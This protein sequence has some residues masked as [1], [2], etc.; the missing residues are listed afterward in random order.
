MKVLSIAGLWLLAGGAANAQGYFDFDSVPGLG[1]QPAVQIDLNPQML[2]FVV[3]MTRESDPEA[4]NLLSSIEGVR[5]RVYNRLDD[6]DAVLEFID[7]TSGI[8]ERDGWQRAVYVQEDSERVRLYIK[9]EGERMAGM[10]VMVA[11]SSSDEA[12]F[13]NVVGQLDP[14][15]LGRLARSAGFGGHVDGLLGGAAGGAGTNG[16]RA[17]RD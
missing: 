3:A 2:N 11:D 6:R 15:Q 16:D 4:A 17:D 8:L 1:D 7:D 5:V 9:F 10:T 12:V 13:V 14:A